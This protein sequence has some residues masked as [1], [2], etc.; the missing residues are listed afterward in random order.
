MADSPAEQEGLAKAIGQVSDHAV[1]LVREEI[2]LAKAEIRVKVEKFSRGLV[3]GIAAGVFALTGLLFLLQSIAWAAWQ[4]LFG[5]DDYWGGFL[6]VAIM[7][8]VL[9]GVAGYLAYRWLQSGSKPAPSMAIDEA[10]LIRETVTTASQGETV[11]SPAPT[12]R[13]NKP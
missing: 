9:A 4:L 2:E 1:G 5:S 8:F 11:A 12:Q 10:R 7:L 3:V 13:E 6:F